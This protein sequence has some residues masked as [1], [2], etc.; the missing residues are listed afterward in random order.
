MA[1][2]RP[3]PALAQPGQ[4][5]ADMALYHLPDSCALPG[6]AMMILVVEIGALSLILSAL[7]L[8]ARGRTKPGDPRHVLTCMFFALVANWFSA[9]ANFLQGGRFEVSII[10]DSLLTVLCVCAGAH[11]YMLTRAPGRL[12]RSGR[13]ITR[14]FVVPV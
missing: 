13:M 12:L 3:Q 11:A 8:R 4:M 10:C 14:I 5:L 7:L 9:L 1:C 6:N 2:V